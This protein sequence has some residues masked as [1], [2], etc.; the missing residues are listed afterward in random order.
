MNLAF[1]I[2]YA[3]LRAD[4]LVAFKTF[5]VSCGG[6]RFHPPPAIA[7]NI[8]VANRDELLRAG[9]VVTQVH[10]ELR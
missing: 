6:I 10:N 5:L 9:R 8:A 2:E 4:M 1:Q 3:K 7:P